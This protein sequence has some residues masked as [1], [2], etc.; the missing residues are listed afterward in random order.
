MNT[1]FKKYKYVHNA[2]KHRKCKINRECLVHRKI[3]HG[4]LDFILLIQMLYL[5]RRLLFYIKVLCYILYTSWTL[6]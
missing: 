3:A 6:P 1:T 4:V 2:T 5:V